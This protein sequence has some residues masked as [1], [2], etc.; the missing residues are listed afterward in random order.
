MFK[1]WKN[2]LKNKQKIKDQI[3]LLKKYIKFNKIKDMKMSKKDLNLH[4]VKNGE[5]NKQNQNKRKK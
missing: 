3:Y 4:I 2:N 1:V 5:L